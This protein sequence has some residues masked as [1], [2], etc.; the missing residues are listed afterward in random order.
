QELV[1]ISLDTVTWGEWKT[2]HPHSDVLSRETGF[3]RD[4][5]RDPYSAYY[6]NNYIC[7]PVQGRDDRIPPMTVIFGVEIDGAFAAYCEENLLEH[8]SIEDRVNGVRIRISRDASGVI[9]VLSLPTQQPIIK[10][11]SYWFSWVAFHPNTYLYLPS[12]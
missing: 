12:N 1:P 6:E 10:M 2:A 8:G 5:G 7:F 4:Y 11:R 3:D 9:S